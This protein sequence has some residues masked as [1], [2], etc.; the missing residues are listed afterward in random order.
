MVTKNLRDGLIKLQDNAA[1]NETTLILDSG[2]LNYT[3]NPNPVINVLD[4]GDLSHMRQGDEVP[5]TLSFSVK[6]TELISQGSTPVTLREALLLVEGASAWTSSNDDGGDVSTI[7]IEFLILS[8]T[9]GE[10]NELLTFTK[11]HGSLEF[12]E[13]DEFNTLSFEGEAFITSPTIAKTSDS[14]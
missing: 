6:F 9:S 12:A 14:S 13:G 4:R 3:E 11:V 5:V 7:D 1:A 2:D 8:P 10:Q